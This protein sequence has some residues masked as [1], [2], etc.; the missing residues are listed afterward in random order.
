MPR[1]AATWR[2]RDPSNQNIGNLLLMLRNFAGC[3]NPAK[4]TFLPRTQYTYLGEIN[5]L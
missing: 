1:Q 5:A 2:G 3:I 4:S